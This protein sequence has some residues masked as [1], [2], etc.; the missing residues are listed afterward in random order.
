MKTIHFTAGLLASVIISACSDSTP[1]D[2][3]ALPGAGEV[4]NPPVVDVNPGV[5]VNPVVEVSGQADIEARLKTFDNSA[6]FY[7]ALKKGL[8][9]LADETGNIGFVAE[10]SNGIPVPAAEPAGGDSSAPQAGGE[11][12]SQSLG[13]GGNDVTTTN[14]QEAGVD[15][16]DR[17]K[18]N[19]AGTQLFVLNNSYDGYFESDTPS[20]S[21]GPAR[22][23]MPV[24]GSSAT[25]LRILALDPDTPEATSVNEITIELDGRNAEGFY[26]YENNGQSSAIIT[27]SGGG[28]WGHW[29]QPEA[30]S[31][32][33][34]LIAK[35]DVTDAANA[36]LSDTFTI[37]GQIISSRRIGDTLFFASRYYPAI[38]GGVQPWQEG[39]IPWRAAVEATDLSTLMPQYSADVSGTTAPLV[40]DS[41]C[42]VAPGV[43]DQPY[44]S[45]DIITLGV[46][47]LATMELRDTECFL[48][49]TETLYANT[50]S[51]FL[52]T[53]RYD[54]TAMPFT[55]DGNPVNTELNVFPPDM[56]WSDART[57][58]DIHQFDIN[59]GQ[60][61]YN[62]S[63]SVR[64]H[65]GW[66]F[67]QKPYRMSE[68]EGYLR[69]ATMN[70]KQGPDH[71]PILLTILQPDGQGGLKTVSS[72]P[73]NN[74]PGHIGKPGEQLYASRFIGE[75][76]YLV[77]FR[78]T[79]PFYVVDLSDPDNPEVKGELEIDGY[80]DYL[81]PVG[82]N[83]MLGIG[84]DATAADGGFGDGRGAW[85][86]G[87]KLSLFD[88][89]DPATPTEVQS[90][91]LGERG[92][93]SGALS[94]PRAITIQAANESHPMRVSF[95]ASVHGN[96]MPSSSPSPQQAAQYKPW[97]YTGL[98]GFD[99]TGGANAAITS[100]GALIIDRS[101]GTNHWGSNTYDDRAVMVN[102]AVFYI[103]GKDVYPAL[104]DNLSNEP[105]AR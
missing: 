1:T 104:W 41:T 66:N 76:A 11:A 13:G 97:S 2:S 51:V 52:A 6:E 29:N 101:D 62:G 105:Q 5:D 48:G 63:G 53:T 28:Y 24:P 103:N 30:F 92:T 70:D 4:T 39:G 75:R 93:E 16:Q 91:L 98:H 19:A 102:D 87:I 71:S 90:L 47:D 77:T 31:G 50:K 80:S 8:L 17:V 85:V 57:S 89:S 55:F 69:V 33:Q 61:D 84:K 14:V 42:F 45:P 60:L 99:V 56:V 74:K 35:V 22:S 72:L 23:S 83:H 67:S 9:N 34:S 21:S 96:A 38:P 37:E 20:V 81:T 54:Y 15:E 46:I 88:V 43:V 25:T 86:Q 3:D 82:E 100:R 59:D 64:G 79:D 10:T 36:A 40:D 94:N 7:A 27:A 49:A 12:S 95:G 58:T 73:N 32:L 18:I 78:Q 65:L 26:L 44:F 68:A